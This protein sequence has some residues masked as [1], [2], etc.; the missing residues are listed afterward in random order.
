MS[1][2][3]E[4]NLTENGLS[5]PPKGILVPT[6]E[7]LDISYQHPHF[8]VYNDT[9]NG[10]SK[11]KFLSLNGNRIKNLFVNSLRGLYKLE[12]LR[13]S[14]MPVFEYIEETAFV[15]VPMLKKLDL[16]RN[17]KLSGTTGRTFLGLYNLEELNLAFSSNIASDS[18]ME[19]AEFQAKFLSL[20]KLRILNIRCGASM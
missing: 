5:E 9:F 17:P 13:L 8:Y 15:H 16:S 1:F 12:E 10:A 2:N 18:G 6:L 20:D 14:N 11:M 4:L 3:R 19:G 7:V